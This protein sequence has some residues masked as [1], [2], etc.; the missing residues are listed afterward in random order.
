MEPSSVWG[1]KDPHRNPVH[2]CVGQRGPR[3]DPGLEEEV[4]QGRDSR[5]HRVSKCM[6]T[7]PPHHGGCQVKSQVSQPELWGGSRRVCILVGR[8]RDKQA[9]ECL[10]PSESPE[11]R[12]PEAELLREALGPGWNQ[13]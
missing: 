2:A 10:S 1:I 13:G 11:E 3:G 6:D 12:H 8:N 9:A 4:K 5:C 7:P